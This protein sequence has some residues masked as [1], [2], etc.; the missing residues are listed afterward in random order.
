MHPLSYLKHVPA[1]GSWKD[2]QI[3]EKHLYLVSTPPYWTDLH[4]QWMN[5][6]GGGETLRMGMNN[7]VWEIYAIYCVLDLYCRRGVV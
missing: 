7:V 6:G 1:G 4:P 2:G 3:N 5:S